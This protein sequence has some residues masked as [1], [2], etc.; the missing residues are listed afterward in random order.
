MM[1][2]N[3]FKCFK[4]SSE[5]SGIY[6]KSLQL[7]LKGLKSFQMFANYLKLASFSIV[8]NQL[9]RSH[10]LKPC[11][12]I[13]TEVARIAKKLGSATPATSWKQTTFFASKWLFRT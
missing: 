12:H 13:D 3:G 11:F 8:T 9:E 5:I 2:L 7:V 4:I 10:L 6:R 1:M